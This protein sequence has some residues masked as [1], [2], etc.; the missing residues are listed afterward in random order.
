MT[1]EHFISAPS[2][3]RETLMKLR[4]YAALA[5]Q[6]NEA[7][8][9]FAPTSIN[10]FWMRHILDSLQLLPLIPRS[11]DTA[12]DIGSGGGLPGLVLAIALAPDLEFTLIEAN[13]RKAAFLREAARV[14]DTKLTIAA[15][16]VEDQDI[17][18]DVVTAR[19]LAPLSR[20]LA[21][22]FPHLNQGGICLFPKGA[23]ASTEIEQCTR[24]WLFDVDCIPSRTHRDATIL[25]VANLRPK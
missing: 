19:A 17:G 1:R 5:R 11:A 16:R 14:T 22:A 23:S 6:W 10:A 7:L 3:S 15:S 13:R 21:M 9:L 24:T 8:D 25:R 4:Q 2:V 18:A 12:I 20:L